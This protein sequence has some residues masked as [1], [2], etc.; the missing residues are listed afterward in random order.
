M[1]RETWDE[2]P[3]EEARALDRICTRFEQAWK[4]RQPSGP[5]PAVDDFLPEGAEGFRSLVRE[6]LARL[7]AEYR[8]KRADSSVAGA[9]PAGRRVSGRFGLLNQVGAG[10]FGSV[11]Q[12]RD[13]K[14][15]RVVALKIPHAGL[16]A[17][18]ANLER[19]YR[20]ARAVA[21]LRHPGIVT[22]HEVTTLDGLP[23]IV[24]DFVA[25]APL[26]EVSAARRLDFR[27]SATL[28]A[29]VAD[30]LDYAHGQ[31][32]IHRDI[33]PGN[34]LVE[35]IAGDGPATAKPAAGGSSCGRARLVDFGLALG[36]ESGVTLTQ[37][38]DIV[39]T[40]AYMSP[41]QARGEGHRVDRRSDV[42]SLGVVLYELLCGELPFRGSKAMILNQLLHEEPQPPRSFND[43][44][45]RDLETICLKALDK[46]PARRYATARELGD[47]LRR[48]LRDEPILARRVGGLERQCRWCRRNPVPAGLVAALLFTLLAGLGGVSWQW[49]RAEVN[50]RDARLR[51][52]EADGQRALAEQNARKAHQAFDEAFTQVSESKLIDVPGAQPLRQQLLQSA[53]RYYQDF[54]AR[55]HDDPALQAD[56]TAAHFRTAAV[57]LALDQG[58]RALAEMRKGLDLADRFL[59]AHG[60]ESELPLRLAGF[61]HSIRRIHYYGALSS[62]P[63]RDRETLQRTIEHWQAFAR[64]FPGEPAF[65]SDLALLHLLHGEMLRSAGRTEESLAAFQRAGG[66]MEALVRQA[67][68]VHLYRALLEQAYSESAD[69]LGACGRQQERE[70]VHR[71]AVTFFDRQASAHPE[72]AGLRLGLASALNDLASSIDRAGGRPQEEEQ[73]IRRSITLLEALIAERPENADY[74]RELETSWVRLGGLLDGLGRADAEQSYRRSLG[75][76]EQLA[77]NFPDVPGFRQSWAHTGMWLGAFLLGR[78]RLSEAE[79]LLRESV[80]LRERLTAEFPDHVIYA[81]G[82]WRSRRQLVWLLLAAGRGRDVDPL[83]DQSERQMEAVAARSPGTIAFACCLADIQRMRS[84]VLALSSQPAQ[85]RAVL[86]RCCFLVRARPE[87]LRDTEFN[88]SWEVAG[89]T[90]AILRL[91]DATARSAEAEIIRRQLADLQAGMQVPAGR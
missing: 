71:S 33:K 91:L 13:A 82:L 7:D 73:I 76:S 85:A 23:V 3:L 68:T 14:L 34:I 47:D 77:A 78:G 27:Q 40:P 53:L 61:V 24:S 67:P 70:A 11:W 74:R 83:L 12:A 6:E 89:S 86:E 87:L 32:V 69:L 37:D 5:P 84:H 60:G 88:F 38:G 2:A 58:D 18:P 75:L 49:R 90:A 10:A 51:R 25:G 15:E 44:T 64:D 36:V 50:F 4:A 8:T 72:I 79:N 42:Y 52:E 43:R 17:V 28:V 62:Q 31:G 35:S 56:V 41:E 63:L 30:A 20:E 48:W 57:L 29:E 39:G 80:R 21:R 46:E 59:Q 45:P 16:L 54:L 1:S 65:R 26:S 9:P 66:L 19:F 55:R 81:V 22:V